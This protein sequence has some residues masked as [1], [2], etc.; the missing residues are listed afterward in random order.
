VS[1]KDKNNMEDKK[2]NLIN[3]ELKKIYQNSECEERERD[4]EDWEPLPE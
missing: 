2:I 4:G 3:G 1:Q